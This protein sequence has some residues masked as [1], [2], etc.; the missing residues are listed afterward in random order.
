LTIA[1]GESLENLTGG[2]LADVLTGNSLVNTLRGGA[3]NDLLSGGAGNDVLVGEAGDDVLS[4]DAG[5]DVYTFD[6]DVVLGSD[7]VVEQGGGGT[8]LLDFAATTSLGVAVN[9]SLT[10]PQIVNSKLTLMLS[11]G[12]VIENVTG[13]SQGDTLLGNG[14]ANLLNG[15]AG[16]DSLQGAAGNDT[17]IGAAGNDSL[18]GGDGDDLYVFDADAAIGSDTLTEATTPGSGID[19][20]DFSTTTSYAVTVDLSLT[21][22]QV[23]ASNLTLTFSSGESLEMIVGTNRNDVLRGNSRDNV[24]V[25]GTGNDSL[26]GGAGRDLLAGGTGIDSLTGEAGEDVLVAGA[27]S[28]FNESTRVLNRLA[29]D[30]VMAEWSRADADY[31]TRIN[32]LRNGGGMSG[33][34][35]LNS[36]TVLTDGSAIDTLSGGFDLDWFWSFAGDALTDRGTGGAETVA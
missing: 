17:L 15:G 8:D 7:T 10:S 4:G 29:I 30:A 26:Q 5:D 34:F 2:A 22:A 24:L 32:N 33:A 9:L 19:L 25:G 11:A 3:G 16:N 20:V 28:Y 27:L 13:S 36:T 12:D 31:A 23:V 35:R 1:N 6:A 21:T 18:A 14:L